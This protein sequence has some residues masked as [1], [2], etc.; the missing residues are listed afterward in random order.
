M[1]DLPQRPEPPESPESAP[2][3][4]HLA[5]ERTQLAWW[6]T[7]LTA[8]AVGL[9]IGRVVPDIAGSAE[10]WPY[11]VTGIGFAVYG[12]VLF[13]YG[14]HRARDLEQHLGGPNRIGSSDRV[15]LA[16]TAFGVVLGLAC[17]ALIAAQ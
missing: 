11:V 13:A 6:R 7:G 17:I 2:R 16:L 9:G 4:T 8:I 10:S 15:L 14:T 5:A 1:P 12:I 3:R